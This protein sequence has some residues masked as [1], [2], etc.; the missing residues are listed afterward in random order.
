M[1]FGDGTASK[2]RRKTSHLNE[3]YRVYSAESFSKALGFPVDERTVGTLQKVFMRDIIRFLMTLTKE[4]FDQ[5]GERAIALPGIGKFKI[6]NTKPQ[7][8]RIL[9]TSD[10]TNVDDKGKYLGVETYPRFKFYPSSAIEAEVEILNGLES[11]EARIVY[12]R[13]IKSEFYNI[14]LNIKEVAKTLQKLF[15]AYEQIPEGSSFSERE[16]MS[17]DNLGGILKKMVSSEVSRILSGIPNPTYNSDEVVDDEE[18][19]TFDSDEEGTDDEEQPVIPEPKVKKP[20][21]PKAKKELVQATDDIIAPI[22]STPVEDDTEDS[23]EDTPKDVAS[24]IA[25]AV[26]DFDFDFTT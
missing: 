6:M 19:D 24:T 14:D 4:D 26:D 5:Y 20:K 3:K 17:L 1:P 13:T 9:H 7:G 15:A 11:E 16:E 2:E 8:R 23:T 25:D 12:D 10:P 18:H 21:K 22:D